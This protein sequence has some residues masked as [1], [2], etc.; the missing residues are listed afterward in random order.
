MSLAAAWVIFPALLG[1]LCLGCG[2]LVERV[3]GL[4]LP[5]ALIPAIGLALI[6]V[7]AQFLTLL[8]GT[9]ELATPAALALAL[10]GLCLA[11][12]PAI[13]RVE[14]AAVAVALLSFAAFAAPIVL[15]GEAT[16]AGY[17]K[18]DDTATWMAL[19]DH[20]MESGRSVDGLAPSTYEATLAFNLADGYPIGAF[21]PLGVGSALSGV[22]VAWVIQP[23]MAVLGAMLALALWELA[24]P[25]VGS[26]VLRALVAVCGSQAALLYGYYLWGGVKEIAAAAMVASAAALA[27]FLVSGRRALA[28]VVPVSLVAA[29]LIGVLSAGAGLWLL[30]PLAGAAALLAGYAG[31]R[32]TVRA[33]AV[34]VALV[35]LLSLPVLLAGGLLPPTSAPLTSAE[36]QGNLLGSLDPAQVAG[37]WPAG[38][39]RLDPASL[40]A[41]YGLIAVAVVAAVGALAWAWRRRAWAV[42]L[43]ASV[44]LVCL[45]IWSFGSPWVDGKA[46]AI[47]SPVIP[48]AAAIGTAALYAGGRRL[49]GAAL[50]IALAA[51]V[52]GSNVL[53]YRHVSLAP[54]DQLAE[55][56]RIAPMIA[57]EGPTLMTEYQPYGVRHFLRRADPEGASE[58]RRRRVSLVGGDTLGK[59][60]YADI[61]RFELTGVL[62]YRTL[63][64]RRG[65]DQSRP[66]LPYRLTSRGSFYE[67]WQRDPAPPEVLAHLGLGGE[68][69]PL[70]VPR[71]ADVRELARA[72]GSGGTVVAASRPSPVIA[73]LADADRPGS[74][75]GEAAE[76]VPAGAGEVTTRASVP[77]AGRYEAWL[78]GSPRPLT[79]LL[80][81]GQPSGSARHRLNNAGLFV[82]FGSRHLDA[83]AHELTLTFRGADLHPGSG[84]TGGAIGPLV[85]SRSGPAESRILELEPAEAERRLCGQGWD[86]IEGVAGPN[87]AGPRLS[88]AR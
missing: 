86:W 67:V 81:D 84:G 76:V 28:A 71:C 33:A 63:V 40:A 45:A 54:R 43:Y 16:F 6:V 21:L 69:D 38:D 64:L 26:R 4:R 57:G 42:P 25:L 1:T 7:G 19:T 70:G 77:R 20:V 46:L 74:W 55:L 35:T 88:A 2:L 5:G 66:P 15:S 68:V 44:L 79:E 39:F 18:L 31:G 59:G 56:E 10:I 85:L 82:S 80:V 51:G 3:A 47:A 36:A 24:A 49:A 13:R 17:I 34:C 60:G 29:A 11:G 32:A 50:L 58:L 14:A 53:Q 73:S 22:D 75:I 9:A 87:T 41:T 72:A 48:F 52:L 62:A 83:G 78:R 27:G 12:R 37:I 8:D 23:Y 65:P 30:P 61:D